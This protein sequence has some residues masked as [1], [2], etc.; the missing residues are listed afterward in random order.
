MTRRST[1]PGATVSSPIIDTRTL[2]ANV[3]IKSGCTLAIGGL[4]QDESSQE[5]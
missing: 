4:L 2:E 5:H 3:L 1:S